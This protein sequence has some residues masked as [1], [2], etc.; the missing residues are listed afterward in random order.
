[1]QDKAKANFI[2]I[3]RKLAPHFPFVTI[4][5]KSTLKEHNAK[6]VIIQEDGNSQG[7]EVKAFSQ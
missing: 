7:K 3:L 1:M 4:F 2:L 6:K 5:L